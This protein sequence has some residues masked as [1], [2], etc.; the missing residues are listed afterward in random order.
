MRRPL[1]RPASAAHCHGCAPQVPAS[2]DVALRAGGGSVHNVA[3]PDR[4][5]ADGGEAFF[6]GL[7]EPNP[8]LAFTSA[9]LESFDPNQ[10]GLFFF[11]VDD[12]TTAVVPEP[13][14]FGLF[15]AGLVG[16][17]LWRCWRRRAA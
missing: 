2:V 7:I 1:E 13:G 4:V 17:T 12:I 11:T 15:G 6:L 8:S 5:L 14:T 9:G 16:A 3:S 10:L